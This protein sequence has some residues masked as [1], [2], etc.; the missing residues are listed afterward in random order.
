MKK[1][2]A[3]FLLPLVSSQVLLPLQSS[4]R[5]ILDANGTRV[6]LRCTNWAGH[7]EAKVPEGFNKQPIDGIADWIKQQNFNCVRLTY[8]IE[9]ALDPNQTVSDSFLGAANS[10]G[11]AVGTWMDIFNQ[12]VKLNPF[13]ANATTRDAF[14]AVVDALWARGVVGHGAPLSSIWL[15]R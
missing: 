11:V 12:S 10:S 1:A 4:S 6:K 7:L 3:A 13:L 15:Q 5:W 14:G 2:L 9:H 8:S